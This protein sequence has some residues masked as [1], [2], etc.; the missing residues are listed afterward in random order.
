MKSFK[1]FVEEHD[2]EFRDLKQHPEWDMDDY[3]HLKLSKGLMHREIKGV[4][5]NRI[6]ARKE[7]ARAAEKAEKAKQQKKSEPKIMKV[8][9][10]KPENKSKK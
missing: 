4:W 8:Q 2:R 6:A 9:V 1:L 7:A 5:D 10:V 3:H